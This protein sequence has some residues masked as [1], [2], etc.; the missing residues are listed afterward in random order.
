ML[1]GGLVGAPA[2]APLGGAVW[3]TDEGCCI[4]DWMA[5]GCWARGRGSGKLT[6]PGGKHTPAPAS[7]GNQHKGMDVSTGCAGRSGILA[8]C[9]WCGVLYCR[10]GT[11]RVARLRARHKAPPSVSGCCSRTYCMRERPHMSGGGG[12]CNAPKQ[13]T[14]GSA[15]GGTTCFRSPSLH[16]RSTTT[17]FSSPYDP[18]NIPGPPNPLSFVGL[19]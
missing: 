19:T 17:L 16:R 4:T 8:S 12:V 2:G 18:T 15:T 6:V 9:G 10:Y 3:C 1:C 5:C 13:R 11:V 14:I 7:A